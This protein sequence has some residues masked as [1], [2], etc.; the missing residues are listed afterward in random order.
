MN[1]FYNNKESVDQYIKMAKDVSGEAL[2]DK[3]KSF[4]PPSSSVLEIGSGPGTD[5]KILNKDYNVVGSD[6]SPEFLKRLTANNPNGHFLELD[7]VTLNTKLRFNGIYSN[8]VLHHLK[9]KD[10]KQ[11]IKRQAE[12]LNPQ[13]IICHSFWEGK[14]SEIFNGMF[15]NYHTKEDLRLLSSELFDVILTEPYAEFDEDDSIL[16]IA[17][18]K[19]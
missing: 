19:F 18:K 14:D 1:E 8:K 4:L 10:L 11:S 2:I 15:V 13:G 3:L 17:K 6:N 9:D 12:I 16:L 7:A 5:W